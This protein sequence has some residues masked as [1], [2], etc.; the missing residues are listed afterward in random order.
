[1]AVPSPSGMHVGNRMGS[2]GIRATKQLYVDGHDSDRTPPKLLTVAAVAEIL[3]VSPRTVRRMIQRGEL[4]AHRIAGLRV[5][6]ESVTRLLEASLIDASVET[7][8]WQGERENEG[9]PS[10]PPHPPAGKGQELAR[11]DR[12]QGDFPRYS[13]PSGGSPKTPAAGRRVPQS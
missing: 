1:M 9:T 4:V 8:P 6:A 13:R 11:L 7:T 12:R 3:S 10:A 5:D 2:E